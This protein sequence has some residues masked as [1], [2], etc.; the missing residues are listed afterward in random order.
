MSAGV[1]QPDSGYVQGPLGALEDF[2]LRRLPKWALYIAINEYL[3]APG[4]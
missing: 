2:R 1:T 3:L 4:Y